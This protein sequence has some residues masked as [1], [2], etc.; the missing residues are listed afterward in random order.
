MSSRVLASES[1]ELGSISAMPPTHSV[2]L[3]AHLPSVGQFPQL[4]D[5]GVARIT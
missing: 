1:G 5:E 3:G 2:I 4:E